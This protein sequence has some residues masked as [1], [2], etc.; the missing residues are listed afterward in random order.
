M[1]TYRR[2]ILV[3]VFLIA[4]YHLAWL[5]VYYIKYNPYTENI[6][7][8]ESGV[9]LLSKDGYHYSVK[10]PSYLSFT[11]NLAITNEKDDLSLII[12]PLLT[13]GYEYGLQILGDN[14]TFY[15][16]VVDSELN[17][18]SDK[19]SETMDKELMKNLKEERKREIEELISEVQRIWNIK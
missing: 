2:V 14:N 9:Y 11:G 6:P 17:Y 13:G 3:I 1:K 10:K 4:T 19:N 16:F 8:T 18:L 12:W 5:G 15:S 7:Q